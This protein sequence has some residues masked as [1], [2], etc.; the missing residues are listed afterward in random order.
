MNELKKATQGVPV[1]EQPI[2]VKIEIENMKELTDLIDDIKNKLV[3][4]QNFK[5]KVKTK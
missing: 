2:T 1:R 3:E 4:L 5:L